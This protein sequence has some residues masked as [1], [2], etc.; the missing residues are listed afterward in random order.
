MQFSI[1]CLVALLALSAPVTAAAQPAPAP[2]AASID[3]AEVADFRDA[4]EDMYLLYL[5]A[6]I[7]G[8]E[9]K[10]LSAQLRAEAMAAD[11]A[12]YPVARKLVAGGYWRMDNRDGKADRALWKYID[13]HEDMELMGQILPDVKP[14]AQGGNIY[15]MDYAEAYD[16]WLLKTTGKQRYATQTTCAKPNDC[17]FLPL[18]EPDHVDERRAAIGI[19]TTAA[20][21]L[22]RLNHPVIYYNPPAK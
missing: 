18:E 13:R 8:D 10:V 11:E 2:V 7:L 16:T 19:T 17:T 12:L 9:D 4:V 22:Y 15:N 1:V 14:V 21:A 20:D 5:Q 3:P 6:F